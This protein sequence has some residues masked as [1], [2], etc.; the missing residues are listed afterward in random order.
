MPKPD[1]QKRKE[2]LREWMERQRDSARARV[3]L[4]AE[5]LD[6]L[7]DAL[8]A[9]LSAH[10]CDHTLKIS[11]SFLEQRALPIEPVLAWFAAQGGFCDCEVLANVEEHWQEVRQ[12]DG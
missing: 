9:E 5:H 8:D 10:P 4:P 3:P 1:K 12:R 6:A 7:F 11:R 2:Q